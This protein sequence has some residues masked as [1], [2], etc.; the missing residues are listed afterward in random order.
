MPSTLWID[1]ALYAGSH[2]PDGLDWPRLQKRVRKEA[3]VHKL[4]APE[5]RL[6]RK[7]SEAVGYWAL[8]KEDMLAD[9]LPPAT[10]QSLVDLAPP[11][12]GDPVHHAAIHIAQYLNE[13]KATVTCT[14][15]A[16]DLQFHVRA[17]GIR[18]HT[19]RPWLEWIAN[20][21]H[22]TECEHCGGAFHPSRSDARFCG[23]A[24]RTAAKRDRQEAAA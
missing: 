10:V 17:E 18:A 5:Q 8:I 21:V 1:L 22:A 12:V 19:L 15:V 4:E 11:T 7:F 6:L 20:P 3:Q 14:D 24:C 9:F 16:D 2:H 23:V 13:A